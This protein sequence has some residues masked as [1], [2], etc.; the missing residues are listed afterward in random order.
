MRILLDT[1]VAL[2]ALTDDARLPPAARRLIADPDSEVR[3]SAASVWEIT[4]KHRLGRGDMPISGDQALQWFNAAGYAVLAISA[5]HAV[6]TGNLPAL[7]ADPFDRLL[8]AQALAE[9]LR[10]ITHDRAVA[11]YSDSVILV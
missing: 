6:A 7:H 5:A 10:L 8:V 9:P 3:V 2:W 11:A 1:H 4:I